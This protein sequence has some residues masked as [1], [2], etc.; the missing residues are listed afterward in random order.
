MD[1]SSRHRQIWD[2]RV[3]APIARG[4]ADASIVHDMRLTD[5]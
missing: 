2:M 1:A 3:D 5:R 4:R